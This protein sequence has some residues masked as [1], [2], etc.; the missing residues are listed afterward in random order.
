[1]ALDFVRMLDIRLYRAFDMAPDGRVLAGSDDSGSTQLV[2][3]LPDGTSVPLTALP[4][5]C[6]GRYLPGGQA[7]IVSHDDGGNERHQLSLLRLPIPADEPAGLD[8]LEPLVSDPRYMHVLA[9][10]QPGLVCYLTNRRNGVD[11]DPVIRWLADGSERQLVLADA[12]FSE[13]SASP[14]GRWL[15]LTVESKITA[16]SAHLVLAD[17]ASAPGAERLAEITPAD[18]QAWNG[19]LAWAPDS[20]AL[21]F[22]SSNDREFTGTARYDLAGGRISWLVTSEDSDLTS[23]LSP[24]GTMLLI[25]R[26]VDGASE[27]ALHDAATGAHV[28]DI[29]LPKSATMND[30]MPRPRWARDGSSVAFTVSGAE[31][32]G[33]VMIAD[34]RSERPMVRR[35]TNSAASFGGQRPTVPELHQVPA[36]G[37]Q[38]VPCMVYRPPVNSSDLAGSAVLLIHGGPESQAKQAFNTYT[39]VLAAAGHTVL[40]P[41]V[42]GSTGYG[43]RWY[44]ADDGH[45][46]MDSVADMAALHAYLPSLGLDQSRAALWGG[47]YGGYMVLAGLAFQPDLWAAGVDIVGIA[48][49]VTFLEN[50]S[51]YRRAYREREYG[52]LTRDREF[53]HSVS[54]LTRVEDIRAPLFL[55]HGAN[56]PRVPLSEAELIHAAMT[57]RGR[58]CELL[59]YGDEGHGLAKRANRMDAVPKALA[60]LARHLAARPG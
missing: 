20:S 40:V 47:S 60:F 42:R 4:G 9:D 53:L 26:N 50:T 10:V 35:L 49:L 1:M 54:P 25:E 22:T 37:G 6:T 19:V 28:R 30:H 33:D 38:P 16:A 59:V 3:L 12:M 29:P 55:I 44:C 57:S 21:Y 23:W 11:F 39:Q 32:P 24:D 45:R 51:A 46:R 27:L 17:L 14:D 58:E 31:M 13:A 34:L 8:Q 52:T 7:V 15:A 5:A 36:P 41:N 2:E 18:A 48:S 43:K 56:D